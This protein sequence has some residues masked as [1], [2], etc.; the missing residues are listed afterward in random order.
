MYIKYVYGYGY[1]YVYVHIQMIYIYLCIR[2]CIYRHDVYLII[3]PLSLG[4]YQN[5]KVEQMPQDYMFLCTYLY[6]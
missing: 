3:K 6:W 1:A 5:G 2:I 4:I